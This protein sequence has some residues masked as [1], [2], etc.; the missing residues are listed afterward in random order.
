MCT[1]TRHARGWGDVPPVIAVTSAIVTV[2]ATTAAGWMTWTTAVA[3]TPLSV[4][5][6]TQTL[7]VRSTA[8]VWIVAA[9]I[10]V[11][12]VVLIVGAVGYTALVT[13]TTCKV[14]AFAP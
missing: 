2:T 1:C 7:L 4:Y 8:R 11:I 10:P 13:W 6:E 3:A 9:V 5:V 12:G 14:A